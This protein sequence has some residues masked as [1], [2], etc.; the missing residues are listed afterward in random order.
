MIGGVL[1]NALTTGE[2]FDLR[3]GGAVVA[4]VT[5]ALLVVVADRTDVFDVD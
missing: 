3:P 2:I 1:V 4:V 5:A